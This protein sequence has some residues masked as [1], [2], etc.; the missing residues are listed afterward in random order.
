MINIVRIAIF[1]SG[2]VLGSY[3]H[4]KT[5]HEEYAYGHM[6]RA[7]ATYQEPEVSRDTLTWQD[8]NYGTEGY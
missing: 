5:G 1:G 2:V 6:T 7:N 4:D 3:M 8:R